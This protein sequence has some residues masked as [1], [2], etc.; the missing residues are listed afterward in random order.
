MEKQIKVKHQ[1]VIAIEE[2]CRYMNEIVRAQKQELKTNIGQLSSNGSVTKVTERDI[3]ELNLQ[4][5]NVEQS[6]T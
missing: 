2:R 1:T 5:K 3:E 4:L 6:I